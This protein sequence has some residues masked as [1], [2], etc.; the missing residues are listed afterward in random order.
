M[1]APTE[2][3]IYDESFVAGEALL[4]PFVH[5][6]RSTEGLVVAGGA[7][8]A[9]PGILQGKAASGEAAQVRLLGR[10]KALVNGTTAIAVG[11]PLT[12]GAN[13]KLVKAVTNKDW[14]LAHAEQVAAADNL[15]I[16][17]T[18]TGPYRANI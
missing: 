6:V 7:G 3:S 1:G 8:D 15:I 18:M 14:V 16:D 5:V 12:T 11:D 4:T 2:H 9:S 17:V 10:S 13:G